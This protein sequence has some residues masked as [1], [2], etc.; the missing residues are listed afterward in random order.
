[1]ALHCDRQSGTIRRI[2]DENKSRRPTMSLKSRHIIII[3]TMGLLCIGCADKDERDGEVSQQQD[4]TAAA[5][6]PGVGVGEVK[7]G[8]TLED[9]KDVLGKPDIDATGISYVYADRGIEVVLRDDK[10]YCIYCVDHIPNAPD[11]KACAYQT[12]QGIGI[13]SSESDIIAAYQE[14]SKRSPGALMY[15]QLGLRFVIENNQVQKII[16]LKPW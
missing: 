10:V 1:M 14:P 2:D 5:I 13:G 12:A 11:V 16:A 7:F 15:P 9:M 6:Q 8:M 4:A 3:M